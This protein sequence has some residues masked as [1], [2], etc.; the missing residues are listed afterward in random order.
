MEFEKIESNL[1][2]FAQDRHYDTRLI[3]L[4]KWDIVT[5]KEIR[6]MFI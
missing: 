5:V 1:P 3:L 4:Y 2:N 6:R